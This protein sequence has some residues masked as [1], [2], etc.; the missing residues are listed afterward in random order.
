MA[1]RILVVDCNQQS[2]TATEQL[3]SRAGYHSAAVT[4]F[5][6]ATRS[7]STDCPDLLVTDVRLGRFNGLHL[8]LRARLDHP[9]LPILVLG[10][11]G[12]TAL[13]A[14]AARLGARF[15]A[16]STDAGAFLGLVADLVGDGDGH[17]KLR[18]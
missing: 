15:V 4:S 16:K 1:P 3:L 14:D 17:L 6:D 18:H 8:A 10:E 5:E 2:S 12:D 7:V 9:N 11:V 13:A